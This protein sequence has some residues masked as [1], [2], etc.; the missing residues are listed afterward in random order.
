M[1][2]FLL[3][4]GVTMVYQTFHRLNNMP[5]IALQN[6]YFLDHEIPVF[7]IADSFEEFINGLKSEE[8]ML[9]LV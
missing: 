2:I 5:A 9:S 1:Q 8:E 4:S 3:T 6:I 7:L